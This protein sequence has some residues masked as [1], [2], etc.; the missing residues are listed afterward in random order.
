[1]NRSN[2]FII[3]LII[4]LTLS[5]LGMM[6]T[7]AQ[8]GP[9]LAT[10]L[11]IT[12]D[13]NASGITF[14]NSLVVNQNV[15]LTGSNPSLKIRNNFDNKGLITNTN[16]AAVNIDSVTI[17]NFNNSGTLRG[18]GNYGLSINNKSTVT[19]LI[20]TGLFMVLALIMT[21]PLTKLFALWL[22]LG[23]LLLQLLLPMQIAL[24]TL[25]AK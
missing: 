1:M 12:A 19:T 11:I 5:L 4:N 24:I 10:D 25:L 18:I 15:T 20:N 17:A 22:S 7:S 13:C 9:C 23:E 21:G 6:C 8:A 14:N 3:L 2:K 16:A